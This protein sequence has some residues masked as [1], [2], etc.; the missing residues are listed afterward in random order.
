MDALLL[1]LLPLLFAAI[2]PRLKSDLL[3]RFLLGSFW[4]LGAALA[5]WLY[6]DDTPVSIHLIPLLNLLVLLADV[7]LLVYF[8][9]VGQKNG[10]LKVSLLAV[11][12]L[13]LFTIVEL[14]A[15]HTHGFELVVDE[16]SRM[17]FLIINIV[18]GAIIFYAQSYMR[19]EE[20]DAARKERFIIYLLLF[21][22]VMNFIVMA[23]HLMLFFFLFEMTT[24]ASFLLIRFRGDAVAEANALQAL[25]MNQ[26]GGVAILLG[27]LIA[28]QSADTLF[29][30]Q[31]LE[32][33]APALVGALLAMAA[34]VKGAFVPF[35]RWLLGAMVAP[36]PVSAI[37]HSATMVK[38]APFIVM[39]FAPLLI[40]TFAGAV[41]SVTAMG[42]FVFASLLALSR[43]MLKEIL[44]L[45]TIA[46][47]ALMVSMAALGTPGALE[48]VMILILFHA[49]TKA[50]LFLV[51][52]VL[53]KTHHLKN[54]D[55]MQ[56]LIYLAPKSV[57]LLVFGFLSLSVPPFG[58]FDA[59]LFAIIEIARN[60]PSEPWQLILL[61]GVVIGSVL[62]SLLYFR[63]LSALLSRPAERQQMRHES[64]ES[65]FAIPLYALALLQLLGSVALVYKLD[66]AW[67]LVVPL[68][69]FGAFVLLQ[70]LFGGVER[71]KEYGCGERGNFV[72]A[73]SYYALGHSLEGTLYR[74]FT[75]LFAGVA[76]AGVLS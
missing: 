2:L 29:I 24:L 71:V 9:S 26:I 51:A 62:F 32:S 55:D 8:F 46:L 72:S 65:G 28:Q 49:L 44:G 66:S 54:I 17:M 76:M 20:M 12:Q 69:L 63:I 40:G 70:R 60:I 36:T 35:E 52:G 45:S 41:I 37:L 33:N 74:L 7:A 14:S 5:L 59:K 10:A 4:L 6:A 67:L 27:A 48:I 53:E 31:L 57:A 38:L 21:V 42:V 68:F 18:G 25:W 58:V 64:L 13:L 22:A 19:Y 23:N 15:H 61:L 11:V 30:N 34:F 56:G 16:L 47:L 73:L 43:S 3:Q 39:K 50:L 75:L 1:I